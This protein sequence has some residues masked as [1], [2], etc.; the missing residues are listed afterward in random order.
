M[1]VILNRTLAESRIH[2][3]SWLRSF[4]RSRNQKTRYQSR[5]YAYGFIRRG[6][7]NRSA[8]NTGCRKAGSRRAFET[9]S[10][11]TVKSILIEENNF[12]TNSPFFTGDKWNLTY[13]GYSVRIYKDPQ[14]ASLVWVALGKL[15][16]NDW[17]DST[18]T[19]S[20]TR[21][22]LVKKQVLKHE[23]KTRD[24]DKHSFLL[25]IWLGDELG[26]HFVGLEDLLEQSDFVIVAVPLTTE[27][28]GLFNDYTFGKMKKSAVFVNVGR[29]KVVDTNS[30][31]KALRNK[32]IFAAGLDVT[33][34]E[35]LPPEHELLKLPNAG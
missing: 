34:P 28:R 25:L 29:G 19:V 13:S 4:G 23:K 17:K 35:P 10:V 20:F 22:T 3:L 12:Q 31:V 6:G 27:T 26:A 30:L 14:S 33:D 15:S 32:T 1:I 11:I 18:W 7:R 5:P 9:R 24:L 8:P 21:A 16:S 2:A